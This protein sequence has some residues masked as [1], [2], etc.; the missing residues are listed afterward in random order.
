[1][2]Q[3]RIAKQASNSQ[4]SYIGKT[5]SLSDIKPLSPTTWAKKKG[6][7]LD[8]STTLLPEETGF[9]TDVIAQ[10]ENGSR[11]NVALI[12]NYSALSNINSSSVPDTEGDIG[13][14]HYFQM[15]NRSFAIYDKQGNILYGPADN[16]TIYSDFSGPWDEMIFS[17]PIVMYDH[18]ADRWVVSNM[19]Y[20]W[21]VDYYEMIAISVTPDPLGEWY[22]YALQF[23]N[24]PDYPKF[25]VWTD[26]YYLSVNEYE[27]TSQGD[28]F[29]TGPTVIA[30]NREDMIIG[31]PD[32]RHI[33]F[34]IASTSSITEDVASFQPSDLDG[35]LPPSGTPNYFVCIKDDEWGYPEDRIWIWE[36]QTDWDNLSNSTFTESKILYPAPF[37]SNYAN[38][39]YIPQ[40]GTNYTLHSLCHFTMYRL[41]YIIINGAEVLLCNHTVE[42]DGINHAGVRWYEIRKENN[43]WD[44]FQQGTYAPDES[45]RWMGGVAMDADGNIGLGYSVSGVDLYPSIRVTGRNYFDTL[46]TMTFGESEVIEGLGNQQYNKRWGDY[47]MMGIDPVDGLTFWYTQQYMPSTGFYD[48]GT[49]ITSFQL[50]RNLTFSVDSLKFLTYQECSEGKPIVV[51]NYSQYDVTINE[52]ENEGFVGGS[53][54]Y[55][56]PWNISLPYTLGVGDSIECVV[57]VDLILKNTTS[58]YE[59]DSLTIVTDYN[60]NNTIICV[61]DWLISENND[62]IASNSEPVKVTV[63][64][65]PFNEKIIIHYDLYYKAITSLE[66]LDQQQRVIRELI[67]EEMT[68]KGSYNYEWDGKGDDKLEVSAG[69]Y[70]YKLTV[71]NKSITGKII[72]Y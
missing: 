62:I 19:A 12:Q 65:N 71:N 22:C 63:F 70:F 57:K 43:S 48:F 10:R 46:G 51:H 6:D 20:D 58:S 47:S 2:G 66:I 68:E 14:N 42:V 41:Q 32:A 35:E 60:Q 44:I 55:I 64:P 8:N 23:E 67:N 52:F 34:H 39:D 61:D 37:S 3:N 56:D 27:I 53:I 21:G 50:H 31:D 33:E 59:T 7:K 40:M 13:L 25:G 24:M 26:G 30:F 69:V 36:F 15:I 49:Q 1:M 38:M 16:H 29:F 17:D 11:S 28:A 5:R 45:C 4:L 18:I 54:W 9:I 72:K